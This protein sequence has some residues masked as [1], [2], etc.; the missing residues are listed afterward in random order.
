MIP[1][2]YTSNNNKKKSHIFV[3]L[4]LVQKNPI[5]IAKPKCT[6]KKYKYFFFLTSTAGSYTQDNRRKRVKKSTLNPCVGY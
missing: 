5:I 6:L 3:T 4:V 1:G 2:P